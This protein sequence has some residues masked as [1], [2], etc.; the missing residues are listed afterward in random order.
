M[1]RDP[2][3]RG[4]Q[5]HMTLYD[6]YQTYAARTDRNADLGRSNRKCVIQ[7]DWFF[8]CMKAERRG[9]HDDKDVWEIKFVSEQPSGVFRSLTNRVDNT[10]PLPVPIDRRAPRIEPR[11]ATAQIDP[12]YRPENTRERPSFGYCS[13]ASETQRSP[14]Q[15]LRDKAD[16]HMQCD[17]PPAITPNP[18]RPGLKS[19]SST[20]ISNAVRSETSP[21]QHLQQQKTWTPSIAHPILPDFPPK[22][23]LGEAPTY[24]SSAA[25]DP[26][27][28]TDVRS[29]PSGYADGRRRPILRRPTFHASS[30][31]DVPSRVSLQ[32]MII[33]DEPM[34]SSEALHE[35]LAPTV[36]ENANPDHPT[37]PITSVAVP[38][39]GHDEPTS[40]PKQ[41]ERNA[42]GVFARGHIVP[43]SFHVL[44]EDDHKVDV[45][46]I[47][48][49]TSCNEQC[50][51]LIYSTWE[52]DESFQFSEPQSSWFPNPD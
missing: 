18:M 46:L 44:D 50:S 42:N 22:M 47:E 48:V 3:F 14:N 24:M 35:E 15:G 4:R 25:D 27:L 5:D 7:A 8:L 51:S 23:S 2:P 9:E 38:S 12:N 17:T 37:A 29:T 21:S 19:S 13:S 45:M 39:G 31:V 11:P 16:V 49:R 40:R 32:P 41:R 52:V 43:C 1:R 33:S 20:T 10:A 6:V 30:A 36:P 34:P 26:R 28:V